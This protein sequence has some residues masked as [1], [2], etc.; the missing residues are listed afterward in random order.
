[1]TCSLKLD[2]YVEVNDSMLSSYGAIAKFVT[3]AHINCASFDYL[4]IFSLWKK[5]C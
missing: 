2:N 3:P 4:N 1:M 5:G